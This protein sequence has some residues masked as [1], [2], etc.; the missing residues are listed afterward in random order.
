[1]ISHETTFLSFVAEFIFF[2]SEL[3]TSK[4][5]FS[6]VKLRAFDSLISSLGQ[7]DFEF[8]IRQA[9]IWIFVLLGRNFALS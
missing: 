1:M 8:E 9:E 2:V 5:E 3:Y 7:S 6:V 4:T